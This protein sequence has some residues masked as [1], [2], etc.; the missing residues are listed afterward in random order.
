MHKIRIIFSEE[1][2]ELIK[3]TDTIEEIT[4]KFA[5][6]GW[7]N[8]FREQRENLLHI[9][10]VLA[11][12]CPDFLPLKK[13]VFR[14]FSTKPQDVNVVILG[15]DPYHNV[16]GGIPSAVGLSFSCSST[17]N[18]TLKNIYKEIQA[19]YPDIAMHYSGDLT[20]WKNQGVFLLNTALTVEQGNP[21]GHLI[22]WKPFTDAVI[23]HLRSV[24]PNCVYLLWGAPARKLISVIGNSGFK[25]EAVHPSPLSFYKGF[26]GCGHF[27]SCND[28][29]ASVGKPAINWSV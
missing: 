5:F 27:K 28:Y 2:R 22:L 11:L 1:S 8:V 16:V 24:N 10:K 20:P 12:K 4:D 7:E 18:P 19:E 17:I 3:Q 9:S 13:D 14:V 23:E 6:P 29:L 15:Q 25:L 21:G 26:F